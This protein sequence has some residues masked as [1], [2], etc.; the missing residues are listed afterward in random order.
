[1]NQTD[2][3]IKRAFVFLVAIVA[4]VVLIG[5]IRFTTGPALQ[6][7]LLDSDASFWPFTVQNIMWIALFI[8]FGELVLR[9]SAAKVCAFIQPRARAIWTLLLAS[10]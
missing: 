8:G 3:L 5:I 7:I 9:W 2:T 1:M 4:A 10:R 6:E